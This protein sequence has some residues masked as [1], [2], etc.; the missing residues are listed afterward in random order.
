MRSFTIED[1]KQIYG[2]DNWGQPYFDVADSGNLVVRPLPGESRTVDVKQ[3]VDELV[4]KGISLP[5]LL[6]FP[7]LLESQVRTLSD[8]FRRAIDEFGYGSTYTPVFPIKVNQRKEVVEDLLQA[9]RRH[10]LGLEAGSKSEILIALAQQ[11]GS[12]GLI[13]CNG[14]KDRAY[15]EAA[16]LAARVGR[17]VIVVMEKPFEIENLVEM[18]T[19]LE[20]RLEI[21]FR[22]RLYSRGSGRWE[23]SGGATSKFGLTTGEIIRGIHAL[24]DAGLVDRLKMLHFHIGSQVTEIRRIKNAIKEAARV[25]A[26]VR[27]MNV[28]IEILDVGGGLGVDYDGSKTSS[29]A[30]VNYSVQEFANDVVYNIMDVCDNEEVPVPRIVSESGRALTAHHSM[31]I[32]NVVAAVGPAS[33]PAVELAGNEP[34]VVQELADIRSQMTVKNHREFLHDAMQQRDEMFSMF[35]LG[36]LSLEDRAKGESLFWEIARQAVKYGRMPKH[37]S[38]ELEDL[39]KQLAEKYICNFSVFQSIPDAWA[40]EQLFPVVPIHRLHERPTRAATLADI[41]CDS[42]GEL[43]R[44]VDLKDIKEY[45]EVHPLRPGAPYYLGILLIGAYQDVMGDYHNLFGSVNE[46]HVSVEA[47]GKH[48]IRRINRGDAAGTVMQIF[49]HEPA[50]LE[51]RLSVLLEARVGDGSLEP[52]EAEEIRREYRAELQRYPYLDRLRKAEPARRAA[53]RRRAGAE[54]ASRS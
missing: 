29:D 21:G 3:L 5:I 53:R 6:R 2:I 25:Y 28:G 34:Q 45:L 24:R 13:I 43:D 50:E 12:E 40:L 52:K 23:K 42:D 38:E 20:G 37:V 48:Y 17:R 31:L 18:A 46:A 14:F 51:T 4:E 10:G 26:K 47:D 49:G 30:S 8:S 15:L 22:V 33:G 54:A 19:K 35:N 27:K 9:G 32:T 16:A 39:E 7:Q 41:T 36:Y 11:M 44:F 1:A